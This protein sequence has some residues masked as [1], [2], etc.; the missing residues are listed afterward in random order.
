ME[1]F[2]NWKKRNMSV[3]DLTI[4]ERYGWSPEQFKL[5]TNVIAKGASPDELELFLH[6]CKNL[7]LDPLKP[8]QI[9]FIRYSSGPG[10]IVVGLEG[11]RARAGRTGKLSGIKR[12]A[13]RDDKGLLTGAYAEVYRSDW[14]ESAREEVS[15]R[16]YDTGRGNWQ[17][18]PETMIKKVA[19]CA[20]LRMAFPDELGGVYEQAEMDQADKGRV[21]PDQPLQIDG[22]KDPTEEYTIPGGTHVKRHLHEIDPKILM[23]YIEACEARWLKKPETM[24]GWWDDFVI[25]AE[26]YLGDLEN[27]KPDDESFEAFK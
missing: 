21:F 2:E 18:M 24:P 11:F 25:R 19:E 20:A 22:V 27:K 8:G 26:G 7:G 15:L 6:R 3:N 23:K 4:A 1:V 17:K 14:K 12:G 9:Y 5:I 10:T 16:E 13:I